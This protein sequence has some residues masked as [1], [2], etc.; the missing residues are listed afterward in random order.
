MEAISDVRRRTP[1]DWEEPLAR[2]GLVAKGVS[3]ALVGVLAIGVAVGVGGD[4]TSRQ[5]AL[6]Q[7][8]GNTFGKVVLVLLIAGFA[9][10]ALWRVLQ[11]M[12]DDEWGKRLGHL[13]RAAIYAGLTF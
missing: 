11:T 6:H 9:A 1:A 12:Q 7:L 13:G 10:Y 2:V 4:T 3:Y 8:A 5:G